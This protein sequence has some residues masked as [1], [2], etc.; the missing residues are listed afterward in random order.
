MLEIYNAE[1]ILT[2]QARA[3]NRP[4]QQQELQQQP[5][6]YFDEVL[7]DEI[8]TNTPARFNISKNTAYSSILFNDRTTVY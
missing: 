3:S 5:S 8:K 6:K 4:Q 2:I 1:V 7:Y